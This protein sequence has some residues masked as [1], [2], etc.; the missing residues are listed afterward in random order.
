MAHARFQR[1]S[2]FRKQR[3]RV[4]IATEGSI[5]E[6]LYFNGLFRKPDTILQIVVLGSPR[7]GGKAGPKEV[8]ERLEQEA[9]NDRRPGDQFW[10]VI[11][12]DQWK[13][14]TLNQI[15]KRCREQGFELAVSNPCFE[16]WLYLHIAESKEFSSSQECYESLKKKLPQFDKVNYDPE[17]FRTGIP[18]ALKRAEALDPKNGEP[19]PKETGTQVYRL[20]ARL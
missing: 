13:A 3:K 14:E 20:V 18:K 4:V 9:A 1:Q 17:I 15:A 5:T 10:V 12:R 2:G 19:W 8:L 11:D 16:F 6:P 7:R